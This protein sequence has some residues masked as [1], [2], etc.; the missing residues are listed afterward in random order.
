MIDHYS[1]GSITI[2]KKNYS[3]DVIVSGAKVKSW[4]RAASHEVNINDLDAILEENPKT[5]I[6][7]S[8]AA[9]VMKVLSS[10]E[11]YL[12]KRGIKVQIK[13]TAEAVSEYNRRLAEPGIVAALHLTC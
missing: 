10:S 6:F 7:G 1:F 9:G 3:H 13:K 4:W 11:E 5:I 8:G 2:N 12:T